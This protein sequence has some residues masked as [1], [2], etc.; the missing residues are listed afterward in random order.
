[1]T[2]TGKGLLFRSILAENLLSS[3]LKKGVLMFQR[4]LMQEQIQH[5]GVRVGDS[6]SI[7]PAQGKKKAFTLNRFCIDLISSRYRPENLAM[8]YVELGHTLPGH[9]HYRLELDEKTSHV[10]RFVLKTITG[11]PFWINGL[12]ARE[13]YVERSDRLYIEDHKLNFDSC[14]IGELAKNHFAHPILRMKHL[15]DS[16]LKIL[17]MGETGTGKTHLARKIHQE[18]GRRGS[19]VAVNLSSFNPMLIES[20]LFGH[21]KGAFTGAL[22][23]RLGAFSSA[24]HGTLFLDEVDSLPLELQT[25]LLTF[26]DNKLYRKVGDSAEKEIKA[27]LIFAAGRPLELLVG[28]G[29][30]RKDFYYRLK[31]GHTVELASL[32]NDPGRVVEACRYYALNNGV[33]FS[34][35]VMDFYQSLAWPGNLRQLFGHFE[36]KKILSRSTKIDFD[37]MDE[38]LLLQSSD[39]I[40]LDVEREL[41]SMEQC[42]LN[43]LKRTLSV[44]EGN[45][46]MAARKLRLT[47]KT[48]RNLMG[49]IN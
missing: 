39:L 46:A 43:H 38:E 27:R 25:K 35:R 22:H 14:G 12:A 44:C 30:F 8:S 31:S 11:R 36:K 48:V 2:N 41:M 47:E 29:Q 7:F 3:L 16:D 9:F 34:Q 37:E 40:S 18:S 19:F 17:I 26:L 24:E 4:K 10:G 15:L 49:K 32:R 42:K 6:C 1:V 33:S 23:E 5:S 45:I 28:Q 20:E 21:K 13:A